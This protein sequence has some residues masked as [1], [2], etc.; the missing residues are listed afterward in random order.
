[1]VVWATSGRTRLH[2]RAEPC[3]PTSSRAPTCRGSGARSRRRWAA[4]QSI[5]DLVKEAGACAASATWPI[6]RTDQRIPGVTCTSSPRPRYCTM[7]RLIPKV[8]PIGTTASSSW[9]CCVPRALMLVQGSGFNYPDNQH[10]RIVFPAARGRP[11]RG[12]RPG[13]PASW[14]STG[15]ATPKADAIVL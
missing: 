1:M 14:P 9:R 8:Y 15:S 13:W 2:R 10:F 5:N 7:F 3:W 6:F 12:H 11:A 4:Y